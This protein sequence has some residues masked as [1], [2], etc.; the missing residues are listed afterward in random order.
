MFAR[1]I[2]PYNMFRNLRN[3]FI[4]LGGK[5]GFLKGDPVFMKLR[6]G[7]VAEVPLRLMHTFKESVFAE[8][9]LQGFSPRTRRSFKDSTVVDVGANVDIFRS[10]GCPAIPTRMW[11]PL[12]PCRIIIRCSSAMFP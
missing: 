1:L 2:R 11:F 8:D 4:Y 12:S 7:V 6:N 10:G 9:Y 5:Y 3:P